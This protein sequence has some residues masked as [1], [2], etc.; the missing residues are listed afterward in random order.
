M[1][2][3]KNNSFSVEAL[4]A[5]YRDF[6]K[7]NTPCT[8]KREGDTVVSMC[9]PYASSADIQLISQVYKDV[10]GDKANQKVLDI[11]SKYINCFCKDALTDAEY[12]FLCQNFSEFIDY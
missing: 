10:L 12:A 9:D 5:K 6:V 1:L 8:S 3:T 2:Q 7:W 4:V 11:M